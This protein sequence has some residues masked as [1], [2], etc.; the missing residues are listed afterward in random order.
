MRLNKKNEIDGRVL[1]RAA[2]GEQ[3]FLRLWWRY[4]ADAKK[5]NL[6]W[7]LTREEFRELTQRNCFYCD[8]T[9][10]QISTSTYKSTKENST[11]VYMGLDRIDST[12][13]YLIDN[14]R[15]CCKYCNSMKSDLEDNL[16]KEQ[17]NRI[18]NKHFTK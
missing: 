6:Y 18:Y 11:Y 14:L 10:F 2:P 3:G 9:P 8:R 4:D 16:F 13:G 5:R 17:I 12:K 1:R 7:D 15:A